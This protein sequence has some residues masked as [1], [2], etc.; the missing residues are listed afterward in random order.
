MSVLLRWIYRLNTN[1][2]VVTEK[3][4]HRNCLSLLS[5]L[6]VGSLVPGVSGSKE[7]PCNAEDL[8][9]IPGWGRSPGEGHGN[10]LQ[11]SYL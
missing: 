2:S 11:Y 9:L 7:S 6:P 3:Q 5:I 1:E 10:P 4:T 8:S